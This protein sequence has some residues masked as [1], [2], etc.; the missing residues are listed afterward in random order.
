MKATDIEELEAG[1]AGPAWRCNAMGLPV[2]ND[3]DLEVALKAQ[4]KPYKWMGRWRMA[5]DFEVS[6]G[7]YTGAPLRRFYRVDVDEDTGEVSVPVAWSSP[8][9]VES[10]LL[11]GRVTTD[12]SGLSELRL[13]GSVVTVQ[14]D[15]RGQEKEPPLWYS[16][17]EKLR[18]GS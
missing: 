17:I 11:L 7:P 5:L 2:L 13:I 8:L 6:A 12:L 16:R 10:A 4:G 15:S 3:A 9:R 1:E 18:R 14:K